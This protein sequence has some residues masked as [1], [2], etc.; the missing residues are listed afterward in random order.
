LQVI[1]GASVELT[2]TLVAAVELRDGRRL[3][4]SA[5]GPA[6]GYPIVYLHGAIGSPR[7][8]TP[9]LDAV[10]DALG[11]RF[12]VVNRPGFGG[13]DTHPGR[14]VASHATDVRQLADA[15]GWGRFSILGVSAGAPYALACAWAMGERVATT[16]AVSCL[17]P[18][19][20][21]SPRGRLR[22]R[23][24]APLAAFGAPWIGTPLARAALKTT[25]LDGPTSTRSMVEDYLVC[26]RDWAFAPE[27]IR[28]PVTFW[29]ARH[30][31]LVPIADVRAFAATVP[32]SALEL[33]PRGG[34]FFLRRWISEV[35]GSLA[36]TERP[37]FD[38]A[39]A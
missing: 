33:T 11:I 28:A 12:V 26:C 35:V 16:A 39:A 31:R 18:P 13:S 14:T 4:Y 24:Q 20:V 36:G 19:A 9:T 32:S 27:A 8:R 29:H 30:D 38:R 2:P 22:A 25:G 21:A 7:W 6:R 37:A 3:T 1:R 10:I 17:P 5:A 34:H 23:Y 15:L